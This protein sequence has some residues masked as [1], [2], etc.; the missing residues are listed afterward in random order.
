MKDVIMVLDDKPSLVESDA[1]LFMD[2]SSRIA[3]GSKVRFRTVSKIS[4]R[5]L[6]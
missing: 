2:G 1:C 5:L 4:A 3:S 6:S